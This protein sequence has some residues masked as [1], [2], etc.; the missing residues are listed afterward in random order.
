MFTRKMHG[1]AFA[2]LMLAGSS[3][4]IGA[5]PVMPHTRAPAAECA[6][7]SRKLVVLERAAGRLVRPP[8]EQEI[9][10]VG[11]VGAGFGADVHVPALQALPG[12]E[13]TAICSRRLS[14]A[15]EV[16]TLAQAPHAFDDYRELLASGVVD[17]VTLAVPPNLHHTMAVA[18][19]DAGIHLLCEKPLA[20]TAAEAR[21]MLRMVHETGVC[22]SVAF[23]RRYEPVR[24]RVKQLVEQGF[25]G[26]LHSVSVIVYRSALA[27]AAARPFGWLM[28]QDKG[29]G[30]LAA[31]GSHYVDL[32]RWWFGEIHAVS[33]AVSTVVTERTHA[34]TGRRHA[35]DADDN[36]AF[37]VRF[38]SGALG[39]ITISYTAVTD[40]GEEIV[41][42]GSQGMLAMH[43]PD[44]LVG[45]R[46]GGQIQSLVEAGEPPPARER[47]IVPF[48]AL[49]DGW[50]HAIRTGEDAS[51]S[52]EDGVKVQEV[53]DAVGRSQHL[54]RWMD[55]SGKKWPV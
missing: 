19:C 29:G 18:A 5:P 6:A 42:S 8:V 40:V 14:R 11:V 53:L 20:R 28:E 3:A 24:Q 51:P 50:V 30:V 49:A 2:N 43:E 33:G 10:R 16:A 32:L 17:A 36:T 52:F 48:R 38:A 23:H 46:L 4:I 31:V 37:I 21:D 25:I 27:P 15:R 54:S 9:I 1:A 55:L 34:E 45:C 44:Q 39:S 12:V 13:V 35:V 26:D 22:H 7:T 47:T 41:A